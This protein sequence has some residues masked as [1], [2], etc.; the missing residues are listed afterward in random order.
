MCSPK[1]QATQESESDLLSSLRCNSVAMGVLMLACS[2]PI[3]YALHSQGLDWCTPL[4]MAAY[5]EAWA[6]GIDSEQTRSKIA[7]L[8]EKKRH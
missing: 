1:P 8:R 7:R 6:L 4:V 2:L 3:A 5:M